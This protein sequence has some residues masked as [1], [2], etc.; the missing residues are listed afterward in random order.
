M[1]K[2]NEY[3]HFYLYAKNWYKKSDVFKDLIIILG[4][5]TG[6]DVEYLTNS[7]VICMMLSIVHPIVAKK[8]QVFKD[9][10]H[11]IRTESKS[12]RIVI[13]TLDEIIIYKLLSILRCTNKDDFGNL[14]K[15]DPEILPLVKQVKQVKPKK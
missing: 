14:A 10:I 9:F 4:E 8:E 6:T 2:V 7:D 1:D 13:L 11:D 3:S 12:K 5:Y 15:P